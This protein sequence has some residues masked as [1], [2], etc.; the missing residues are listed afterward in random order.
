MKSFWP[1]V[2]VVFA[3]LTGCIG[4]AA[5]PEVSTTPIPNTRFSVHLGGPD[6]DG[7]YHYY[8]FSDDVWTHR[9]LGPLRPEQLEPA[10]LED[11]GSGVFRIQWG[12]G[13]DDAYAI[14]D[15]TRELIV[16]DSHPANPKNQAFAKRVQATPGGVK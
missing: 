11:L 9:A 13:S 2:P 15:C 1:S 5:L 4:D 16:E 3:L 6:R 14:I 12:D 8:V 10:K 7:G